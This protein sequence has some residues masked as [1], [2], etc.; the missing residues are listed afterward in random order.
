MLCTGFPRESRSNGLII[1]TTVLLVVTLPVV[2]LKLFTRWTTGHRLW[3]DDYT[4][5]AAAVGTFQTVYISTD[6]RAQILL[7][8]LAGLDIAGRFSWDAYE[9]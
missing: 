7:A 3:A 5:L 9:I 2:A 1:L 4:S 8:A 6:Q